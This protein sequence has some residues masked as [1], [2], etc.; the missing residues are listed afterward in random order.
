[1]TPDGQTSK[2]LQAFQ[3]VPNTT[4]DEDNLDADELY[5]Q[6]VLT[7]VNGAALPPVKSNIVK[8]RF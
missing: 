5:A 6:V 1:M 7:E 2:N 3:V 4:L 8:H